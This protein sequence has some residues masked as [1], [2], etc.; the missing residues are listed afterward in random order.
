M[1]ARTITK[2]LLSVDDVA[3]YLGVTPITVYRWC[4]DGRLPST[5]IG[6]SWRIHRS[7]LD[8]FLRRGQRRQTLVSHLQAFFEVP[9]HVIAVAETKE[10]L[11]RLDSA[12]FQ[13][14]EARGGVLVKF[15]AGEPATSDQLRVAFTR[16]GL[17]VN[18][19]EGEGRLHFCEEED[20]LA[21]RAAA[22]RRILD[23]MAGDGRTIWAAFDWVEPVDLDEA[24]RQ[25]EALMEIVDANHL[26]IKTSVLEQVVDTW[27]PA[28]QRR[29][30]YLHRGTI[31]LSEK[32][33]ALSRV[34]PT[35]S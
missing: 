9:D 7:A 1:G 2:D 16:S 10:V 29:A 14:G 32:R 35:P 11:H 18:R 24:L 26:V 33:L 19:L 8:D 5:K 28:T 22:L 21:G 13:V 23:Q 17:E 27:P 20:P 12:F 25:Q 34:M 6:K 4:R 3:T 15:Y 30:Q 31:W